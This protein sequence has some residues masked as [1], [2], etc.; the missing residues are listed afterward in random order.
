MPKDD[1][2]RWVHLD[3]TVDFKEYNGLAGGGDVELAD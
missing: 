2:G 1:P 3:A